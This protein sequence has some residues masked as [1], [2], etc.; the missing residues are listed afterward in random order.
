MNNNL[1]NPYIIGNNVGNSHAF[2]GREDI[3]EKILSVI[4]NN[5][6]NTIALF[7]QRR[8]GKTSIL[9]KLKVTLPEKGS[10]LPIFIDFQDMPKLSLPKLLQELT[11]RINDG[12]P[13]DVSELS[14]SDE[15]DFRNSL[16]QI[17][18][19]NFQ[20]RKL[21]LLFDEFDAL[22]PVTENKT[23]HDFF[24]YIRKLIEDI[25]KKSINFVF[26]VGRNAKDLNEIAGSIFK[27]I[28][29]K[30]VSLLT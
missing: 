26:S 18:K 12:L 27:S 8:I 20:E 29:N 30:P 2:V 14:C 28:P 5:Y 25:D 17:L 19:D 16:F 21:V 11:K 1:T 10:Y 24:P 3:L 6:Q 7:G 4:E 13:E 15:H 9:T 22:I 23:E